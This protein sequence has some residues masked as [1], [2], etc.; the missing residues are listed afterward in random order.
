MGQS[1]FPSYKRFANTAGQT[2]RFDAATLRM[3]FF[4]RCID[5]TFI[6]YL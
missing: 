5:D 6:K 4:R 1:L 2:R 3:C